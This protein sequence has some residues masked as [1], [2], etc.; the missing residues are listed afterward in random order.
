MKDITVKEFGATSYVMSLS[1]DIVEML[2]EIG[3]KRQRVVKFLG[4]FLKHTE[5]Q[6]IDVTHVF[7]YSE[8]VVSS[9]LGYNPEGQYTP[10]VNIAMVFSLQE[11]QPCFFRVV[12][13]SIRDVSLFLNSRYQVVG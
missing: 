2:K 11:R 10:Q 1:E 12:C 3:S 6:V 7:S 5:Y 4:N 8:D 13:G 9:T